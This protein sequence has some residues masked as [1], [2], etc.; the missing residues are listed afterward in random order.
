LIVPF[1]KYAV[2]V[3]RKKDKKK[4]SVQPILKGPNM[5]Q[6]GG[7]VTSDVANYTQSDV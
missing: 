5:R 1:L 3:E 4:D 2:L 7:G 6:D